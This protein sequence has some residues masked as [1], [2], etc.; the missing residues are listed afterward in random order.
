MEQRMI[1]PPGKNIF[2]AHKS[3]TIS[4]EFESFCIWE[5]FARLRD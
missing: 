5:N 4:E 2:A 1:L 3:Q